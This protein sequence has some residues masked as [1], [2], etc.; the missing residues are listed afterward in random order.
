MGVLEKKRIFIVFLA[1]TLLG[2]FGAEGT[3]VQAQGAVPQADRTCPAGTLLEPYSG[4]CAP[5]NDKIH[6]FAQS[7]ASL[8]IQSIPSL[9]E[10]RK[11]RALKHGLKIDDAPVPGGYGGGIAYGSGQ[12][13]ALEEAELHTKMF[14]YPSGWTPSFPVDWLFTPATNRMD[15]PVE[16]VGIYARHQND[17]GVL[18]LFGRSCSE[19]YPCPN[20]KTTGSWQ[21]FVDFADL[22]CN[23]TEIVDKGGH[24]Q[25]VLHY[26]NTTTKL[27]DEA[28]PLWRNAVYIWNYCSESWD[29]V[30]D[31]S[32]REDKRD[33]SI[34]GCA[35]WGPI[36]E[37]FGDEQPEIN[38][39]GFEDTLLY[40]DGVWSELPPS[41]TTFKG[42]V[43]PWI[44][45]HLDPNRGF[46]AGNYFVEICEG[47]FDGD[48]YVDDSDLAVFAADF[49]RIDC[50]VGPACDGD[51]NGF[52]L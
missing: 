49:G 25:T 38:E 28:P 39:L 41:E 31:H 13:Q 30:Y 9:K 21:W 50:A 24:L 48:G 33:C 6:I 43:S 23:L 52:E 19:D 12:L 29:L 46:G 5:I 14:V 11:K 32:Y 18:G 51:L 7:K 1:M 15:N 4:I 8:S 35:W 10:L 17:R 3:G 36:L 22:P 16:L 34:E 40:H 37:T 2:S 44:L 47:D 26:A 27:D 42:P 45:F 20:G